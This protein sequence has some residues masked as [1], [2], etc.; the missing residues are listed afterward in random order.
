[1][2]E[3]LKSE[4]IPLPYFVIDAFLAKGFQAI[5]DLPVPLKWHREALSSGSFRYNLL[6]HKKHTLG[7]F[8]ATAVLATTTLFEAYITPSLPANE[9]K[10]ASILLETIFVTMMQIFE[11]GARQAIRIEAQIAAALHDLGIPEADKPR[12]ATPNPENEWARQQIATG[13]DRETIFQEWLTRRGIDLSKPDQ[14][15]LARDTFRKAI[16]RKRTDGRKE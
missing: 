3:P 5:D 6:N 2:S 9:H 4:P 10:T 15:R 11:R 13:A 1:M 7:W 12:G 8:E 14:E 16:A